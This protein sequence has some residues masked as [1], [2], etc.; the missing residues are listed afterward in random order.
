[1]RKFMRWEERRRKGREEKGRTANGRKDREREKIF[2]GFEMGK[3]GENY[4]PPFGNK[5]NCRAIFEKACE[6][7]YSNPGDLENA[8]TDRGRVRKKLKWNCEK[9][10]TKRKKHYGLFDFEIKVRSSLVCTTSCGQKS[11]LHQMQMHSIAVTSLSIS[12][13]SVNHVLWAWPIS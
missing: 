10:V 9:I 8:F 3:R 4:F 6:V 12:H 11:K 1:M 13:D 5:T 2:P 7:Q